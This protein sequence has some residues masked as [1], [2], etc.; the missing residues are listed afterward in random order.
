MKMYAIY[1]TQTKE[2]RLLVIHG[3]YKDAVRDLK[4][5]EKQSIGSMTLSLQAIYK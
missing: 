2:P 3:R 1:D 5:L 4:R